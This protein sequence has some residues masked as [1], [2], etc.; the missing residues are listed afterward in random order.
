VPTSVSEQELL[1]FRHL[2]QKWWDATGPMAPLHQIQPHRL[3]YI[4]KQAAIHFSR[5]LDTVLKDLDIVDVGCGGGLVCEPLARMEANVVGIDPEKQNILAAA[6]HAKGQN[7]SID[8]KED[9]VERFLENSTQRFD[10]VLSLEVI[11]H[12]ENINLYLQACSKLLKPTGILILSTLNRTTKSFLFAILGAEYC[13]RW[14]PVGTHDWKKFV[15]PAELKTML[16]ANNIITSDT[17]GLNYNAI[18]KTWNF[19]QT[20][21]PV[22]YFLTGTHK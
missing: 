18:H 4:K 6:H 5:S 9:T 1:K 14:L 19:S 16:A 11:E 10:I 17:C 3:D 20:D 13:L 21:F 7:L 8:Y 2:G 22:N 12:V 15:K